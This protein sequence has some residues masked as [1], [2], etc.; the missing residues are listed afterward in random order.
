ME[1]LNLDFTLPTR[2]L[3]TFRFPLRDLFSG[4]YNSIFNITNEG[5]LNRTYSCEKIGNYSVSVTIEDQAGSQNTSSFNLEIQNKPQAPILPDFG[6]TTIWEGY[7]YVRYVNLETIDYDL[8]EVCS[9]S[10]DSLTYTSRFIGTD[11]LFNISSSG[12]IGVSDE[13]I[14]D[15]ME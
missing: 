13:F 15:K 1:T 14:P 8:N 5:I 4:K 3:T 6:N 7:K 11:A 2:L 10:E 9:K 12:T